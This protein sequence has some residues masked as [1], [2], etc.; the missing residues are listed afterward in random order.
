MFIHSDFSPFIPYY[1]TQELY[2]SQSHQCHSDAALKASQI[3]YSRISR[4]V[5]YSKSNLTNRRIFEMRF[6]VEYSTTL[7]YIESVD[8]P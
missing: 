3:E 2:T 7:E 8:E 1:V 4:T 6:D 5:E